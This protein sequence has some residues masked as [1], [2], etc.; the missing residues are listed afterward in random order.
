LIE[1]DSHPPE[2]DFATLNT[3]TEEKEFSEKK[4]MPV[5]SYSKYLGK[6]K[7][8]LIILLIVSVSETNS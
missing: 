6:L 8:Y 1:N 3:G 7:N 2:A 4:L 5:P